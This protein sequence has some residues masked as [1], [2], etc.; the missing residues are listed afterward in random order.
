MRSL[1]SFLFTI[2]VCVVLTITVS[3]WILE[4]AQKSGSTIT[5]LATVRPQRIIV[6]DRNLKIIKILSNT[7]QEVRPFVLLDSVDGL[8]IPYSESIV[9]Q[10]ADL[11]S[12]LDFSK[13]GV[14][15]ERADRGLL[16]RMKKLIAP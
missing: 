5:V 11:K 3:D 14:V 4:A 13:P 10:Y 2:L 7:A 1:L 15:Y 9:N 16:N 8:E 6:V 12:S